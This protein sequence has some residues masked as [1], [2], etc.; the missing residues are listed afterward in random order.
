MLRAMLAATFG[1][2]AAGVRIGISQLG[3]P[4]DNDI[5]KNNECPYWPIK[6]RHGCAPLLAMTEPQNRCPLLLVMA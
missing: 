6:Q 5:S 2:Q 4:L 3:Q 1:K